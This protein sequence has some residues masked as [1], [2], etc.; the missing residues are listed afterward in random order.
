MKN[1]SELKTIKGDAY[2]YFVSTENEAKLFKDIFLA[3]EIMET[4]KMQDKY[5]LIGEKGSGKTAYSVFLS[6]QRDKKIFSTIKLVQNTVYQKFLNMK[7]SKSLELSSFKDIWINIIYL[8]IC[9]SLKEEIGNN[10][11]KFIQ[12]NRI[13]KA[14]NIFYSDSF[15][16]EFINALEFIDNANVS[17]GTM[18]QLGIFNSSSNFGTTAKYEEHSYQIS[19][20]KI[21]DGFEKVLKDIKLDKQFILFIDGIDARP[22]DINQD[23]YI[24]CLNGLVNAVLEIDNDFLR[25]KNIKVMLSIRP[26]IIFKMSIHN[27]NQKIRDNSVLLSWVTTYK[28]FANSKLFTIA[29]NFF[30]KQQDTAC[31]PGTSWNEYFTY[32]AYNNKTK[33]NSD[34]AF[35]DFLR[36]SLY[37]PRDILTMLNEL[38]RV[39]KGKT[40]TY[41]NF[42]T[43]LKNYSEYLKGELKDYMLIYLTDD[44]YNSFILFFNY[45]YKHPT[46]DYNFFKVKHSEYIAMLNEANKPVPNYMKAPSEALQLL[47]DSNIICY[48]EN[49]F[50][51]NRRYNNMFWSYKERSY[52]NIQ[53]EV[54]KESSYRFHQGFARA[55]NIIEIRKY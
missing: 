10:I 7:N 18:E 17:I 46:F 19:L 23:Q 9:E 24:A 4:I 42:R 47:Y 21:R 37:K 22:S 33:S 28:D 8:I 36:Y 51:N 52:A 26:D 13:T 14:V 54:K 31:D 25:D 5:F 38:C 41:D 39:G 6:R 30:A 1:I 20:M 43:I 48:E 15:K 45:F 44:E 53:P 11:T 16:P 34:N 12:Y 3:D 50:A 27:M 55:F 49:V 29:D 2:D 40:F 35:I 32:Q